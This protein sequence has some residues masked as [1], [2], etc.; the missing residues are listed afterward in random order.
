MKLKDLT[1]DADSLQEVRGGRYLSSG[2]L[3]GQNSANG[4]VSGVSVV[5]GGK[6]NL[7]PVSVTSSV[8]QAND[9]V[10]TAGIQDVTSRSF[11]LGIYGSQLEFG[12]WGR[13]WAE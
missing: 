7:S 8:G 13:G 5:G 1:L 10:Q 4:G 11:D 6:F 2:N 12:V 3:I 9:T